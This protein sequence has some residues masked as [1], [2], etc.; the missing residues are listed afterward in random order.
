MILFLLRELFAFLALSGVG[1]GSSTYERAVSELPAAPPET[2]LFVE[3][4]TLVRLDMAEFLR[5]CGYRVYEAGTAKEAIE[6]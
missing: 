2:I 6:S 3:D 4:E 1:A 5:E